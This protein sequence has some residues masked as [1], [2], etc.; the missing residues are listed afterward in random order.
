MEESKVYALTDGRGRI[1]RIEGGCSVDNIKDPSLWVLIDQGYGD[2]YEL[3]Q[4]NY[5]PLFTEDGIPRYALVDGAAAERSR[6][7][8]DG[9]RE[10][11]PEPTPTLDAR[12]GALETTTDDMILL[13]ADLIGGE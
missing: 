10:A 4:N 2:R 6:E 13:M 8:L 5:L 11:L 12:V 9:D 1:I 7:E 3:C